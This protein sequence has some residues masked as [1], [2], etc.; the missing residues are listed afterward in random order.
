[1]H[2]CTVVSGTFQRHFSK[3][4]FLSENFLK[5]NFLNVIFP[6]RQL[7]KVRLGLLRRCRLQW[8]QSLRL[9]WA[10]GLSA[11]AE[12]ATGPNA[13]ARADLGS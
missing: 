6:K 1:M 3:G 12:Q 7:P 4:D 13:A 9:G 11:A 2:A 10:R 8:S 5:D